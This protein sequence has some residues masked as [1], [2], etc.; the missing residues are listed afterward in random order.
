MTPV[1]AFI[2]FESEEGLQRMLELEHKSDFIFLGSSVA[3]KEA[4]EPTN[5]IWENR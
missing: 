4:T 2:S 5:I 1:S 3:V